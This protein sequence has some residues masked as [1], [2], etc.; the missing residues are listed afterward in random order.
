M[1][2]YMDWDTAAVMCWA[3]TVWDIRLLPDGWMDNL[4][5]VNDDKRANSAGLNAR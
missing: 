5:S 2:G 3:V 4:V 1:S